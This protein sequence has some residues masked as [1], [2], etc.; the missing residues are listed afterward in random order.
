MSIEKLTTIKFQTTAVDAFQRLRVT[1][2]FT[3]FDSK[4]IHDGQALFWDDVEESGAG[5]SS[6]HSADNARTRLAVGAATAGLRTRQTFMRFNYQ[7]GKSYLV[8]LTGRLTSGAA[9]GIV[10]RL[11][12][13]DDD[14][15]LFFEM[16]GTTFGCV[17][18]SNTSG[19]PVDDRV[20]AND[21]NGDK[22][23]GEAGQQSINTL[24]L[25]FTKTQIF[26]LDFEWLGVGQVRMGV[27]IDGQ[28]VLL[29]CFQNANVLDQVYM[30][31]PNLPV[32]YQIE[33][34]GAGPATSIDHMCASIMSEG[35]IVRLG[36]LFYDS[37]EGSHIDCNV[38][39]TI[40]AIMGIRLKTTHLGTTVILKN[41]SL[42]NN[43]VVDFEWMLILNP[44]L[45]NAITFA[46]V[47]GASVQTGPGNTGNPSNSTVTGGTRLAGGF[48]K[49]SQASGDISED[50]EHAIRL[51]AS[52][53]GVRDEIYLCCRP[54]SVNAD[55]D[56]G[57]TW[58]EVQ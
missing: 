4:Q 32:R 2:P 8:M 9:D 41:Q 35:T 55:I 14:N 36:A 58:R 21:M 12:Y 16:S 27:V 45:A 37:T 10:S 5:T 54:L 23:Q 52:I 6:T 18:R 31:T 34:D 56:G 50:I 1:Q 28:L 51:G 13:F 3:L 53:A 24:D 40:Y 17:R 19:T 42:V 11:G 39:D 26:W 46:D 25:D 49:S 7:P 33:N 22:F 43:A 29:H 47:A 15:G 30:S 20:A 57:L 38:A 48:V 44:T